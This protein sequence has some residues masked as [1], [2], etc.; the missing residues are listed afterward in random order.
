MRGTYYFPL[1]IQIFD[2]DGYRLRD[3]TFHLSIIFRRPSTTT[4]PI[5][6]LTVIPKPT[7]DYVPVHYPFQPGTAAMTVGEAH[8][9]SNEEYGKYQLKIS[10]IGQT[11]F[12]FNHINPNIGGAIKYKVTIPSRTIVAY[13]QEFTFNLDYKGTYGAWYDTLDIGVRDV[14]YNNFKGS[15]GD[16]VSSIQIELISY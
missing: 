11:S 8:F 4:T 15:P 6:V 10:P 9:Q 5:T 13:E 16:Y 7:A 3:K 12:Q 1:E 14:N 2:K